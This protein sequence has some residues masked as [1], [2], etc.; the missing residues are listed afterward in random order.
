MPVSSRGLIALDMIDEVVRRIVTSLHPEKVVLFGSYAR[1]NPAKDSDLDLLVV[2]QTD[3]PRPERGKEARRS[4]RGM[5]IPVDLL[6]YTPAEV[7]ENLGIGQ[8]FLSQVMAEG[9]VLYEQA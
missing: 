4:L 8:S 1:G 5:K 9:K 7:K 6:I 2:K 3:L